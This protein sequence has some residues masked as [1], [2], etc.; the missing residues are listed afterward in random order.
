MKINIS[1]LIFFILT[2]FFIR[3]SAFTQIDSAALNQINFE[4]NKY[5]Y[6]LE[7][8]YQN[9]IDSINIKDVSDNTFKKLLN[10]LDPQ[11]V[12]YSKEEYDMLQSQNEGEAEGIGVDI[13]PLHD[14]LTIIY[15][16]KNS[17]ADSVGLKPGDKV[18]FINGKS[19]IGMTASEANDL[20]KGEAGTQVSLIIKRDPNSSVLNEYKIIRGEYN[21]PSVSAAFLFNNTDIAYI[22]INRFSQ[23]SDSEFADALQ[24]LKREGMQRLIIDL[25]GNP[26]GFLD[27]VLEMLKNFLPNNTKLLEMK[28]RNSKFDTVYY[29]NKN[30]EYQDLD[31]CVLIDRNSASGSEIFAGVLQ[32][33]DKAVIIGEHSFGKG[34]MQRIWKMSDGS[35]FRITLAEY[36]TPSGRSIQKPLDVAGKTL[37]DPALNLQLGEER[38]KNLEE[39]IKEAGGH[40]QLPIFQSKSGRTIIGGGGVFPDIFVKND[41]LTLLTRVSIQKGIFLEFIYSYLNKEKENIIKRYKD[42]YQKFCED[43]ELSD[44]VL[45]DYHKYSVSRRIWNDEYFEKDKNYIRNYLK[46]LIAYTLW[47]NNGFRYCLARFDNPIKIAKESFINY[48]K[49]LKKY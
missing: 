30:G 9:Y 37:I 33:Y 1:R 47:D 28:G 46:S 6:I 19:A 44:Q 16:A 27:Q 8:I 48:K 41:T 7:T 5:K 32:D 42:D 40:T 24:T 36:K 49:I 26:G 23:K 35:G 12:Y 38:T 25:R 17:P 13:V 15:I 39:M 10:S 18:L 29:S 22:L 21:I 43:F 31:I 2:Y 20:I 3:N 14:T 4:A 11:S 45:E 34:T